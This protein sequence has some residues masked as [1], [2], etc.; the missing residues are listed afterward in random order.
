MTPPPTPASRLRAAL[1]QE[2]LLLLPCPYDGL[3]AR[4]V[5]RAGF[6]A[7]FM[8]GYAVAAGRFG[9]PDIGLVTPTEMLETAR[10]II[11]ASDLPVLCDG[12]TGYGGDANIR[13][14]VL[15]LAQAGAAAVMIEDQ[16]WPKRCGHIAG[17][18]VVPRDEAVA[19]IRAAVRARQ[20]TGD[21][22]LILART[23][24]R[25]IHGMD[26]ALSRI[27]AFAE[28][29]ADML[30]LEAPETEAEMRAFTAATPLP[31]LANMLEGGLTPRLSP[32]RLQELGFAMA[33]YPLDLLGA[34][35]QAM[36]DTLAALGTPDGPAR[37]SHAALL[38]ITGFRTDPA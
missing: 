28:A 23:D 4:L 10:A 15:D 11:R 8:G 38:D 3:S 29:G 22:I 34:A 35:A 12:D 37:K 5:A 36:E 20:E 25:A 7:A 33:A 6:R 1:A 13:R 21:A 19:R 14:T 24:A 32:E 16:T 2:G 27:R 31:C 9:W 18:S 30:F 26:E 17:K